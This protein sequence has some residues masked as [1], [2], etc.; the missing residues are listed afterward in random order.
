[1]VIVLSTKKGQYWINRLLF[2]FLFATAFLSPPLIFQHLQLVDDAVRIS[3]SFCAILL[4]ILSHPK[5]RRSDILVFSCA[6]FLLVVEVI[7]DRSRMSNI[8]SFYAVIILSLLLFYVLKNSKS[9]R[10]IILASWIR[11]A[12][13]LSITAIALSLLHN[14]TSLDTDFFQFSRNNVALYNY[15]Y[16]FLGVTQNK[17][18]FDFDVTRAY[19]Y[20]VEAQYAGFY[21]T[22]N[23]MIA[24][25]LN[26]K[27]KHR[28][29]MVLNLLAGM[30]TFSTTFFI[31]MAM[32]LSL[33]FRSKIIYF[34]LL[35]AIIISF[36]SLFVKYTSYDERVLRLVIAIE[37]LSRSSPSELLL[38]HGVESPTADTSDIA[39][40][41]VNAGVLILLVERGILGLLFSMTVMTLLMNKNYLNLSVCWIWLLALNWNINYIYWIGLLVLWVVSR[42][43]SLRSESL[44]IKRLTPALIT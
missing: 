15:R 21:F 19:S 27:F 38:G 8:L 40:V 36:G 25:A 1:M 41:G 20:F 35:A 12:Y 37:L 13:I 34:S 14:F 22:I 32:L 31:S 17:N 30:L 24:I 3:L 2:A 42:K 44:G 11:I 39:D 4:C 23:V 29:W 33:K 10:E 16:S 26:R 28:V 7:W 9:C 6:L 5:L 18:I 43:E